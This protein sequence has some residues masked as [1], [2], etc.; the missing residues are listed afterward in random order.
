MIP[1]LFSKAGSYGG[2]LLLDHRPLIRNG[3]G[4]ADIAN[5]LFHWGFGQ[6]P[7]PP[8]E[9]VWGGSS[10]R[11]GAHRWW[12]MPWMK[13]TERSNFTG[14]RMDVHRPSWSGHSPSIW[15]RLQCVWFEWSSSRVVPVALFSHIEYCFSLW[16]PVR[17]ASSLLR[18]GPAQG[19][20]HLI[21]PMASAVRLPQRRWCRRTERLT[22]RE[23][24]V[25]VVALVV[26]VNGNTVRSGCGT[27]VCTAVI[28]YFSGSLLKMW[29]A[30]PDRRGQRSLSDL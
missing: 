22:G 12:F 16:G 11:T 9:F 26:I 19:D 5:E 18:K 3:L 7:S 20:D 28:L 15:R 1:A 17:K 10:L 23:S 4:R 2:T 30:V 21:S 25:L 24:L 6:P 27:S 8:T 14:R 29:E 13:P